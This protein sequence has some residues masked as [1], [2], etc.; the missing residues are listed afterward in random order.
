MN[1]YF[2]KKIKSAF[3]LGSTS[4]V[5]KAICI[6]LANNHSCKRFHLVS[7]NLQ[8]NQE[9]INQLKNIYGAYV[10][11]EEID[12]IDTAK[13]ENSKI[14]KINHFDL[15]LIA[16]GSLGDP[17]LAR[18]DAKAA[19]EITA[20]NYSGII[21]W[22]TS[23]T[24][25]ERLSKQ[26]KLWIFSSVAADR[27][28]PSNYHYGAAKAALTTFCEGLFLR[29][30]DK[31]FSIRI[32]KA[33]FIQSPMTQDKAPKILCIDAKSVAKILL[34]NPNR[35]GIEYLPWWWILIMFC[36]KKMPASIACKL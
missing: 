36:V 12:L 29:C 21:P 2:N 28:R 9:L 17:G 30:Q 16:T 6:E 31:P 27:G 14:P 33:G 8:R 22:I 3:I 35:R 7:R 1:K 24:S 13:Y 15:Y 5:A 25:S 32:I 23:I 10:T 26:G 4:T 20:S 11:N 18:D 34:R 19:L